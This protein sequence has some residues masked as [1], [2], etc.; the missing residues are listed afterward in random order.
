MTQE[1]AATSDPRTAW[2]G[3]HQSLL[4]MAIAGW[5]LVRL[6]WLAH[7]AL[8]QTTAGAEGGSGA[9]VH[10][11]EGAMIAAVGLAL[12]VALFVGWRIRT[13]AA[14]LAALFALLALRDP[15]RSLTDIIAASALI[16]VVAAPAAPWASVD[17][18]GRL[19]PDGGWRRPSWH[20]P[21][22]RLVLTL[23]ASG[24]A[25]S[26]IEAVRPGDALRDGIGVQGGLPES[27]AGDLPAL[28]LGVTLLTSAIALQISATARLGWVAASAWLLGLGLATD[29]V[30]LPAALALHWLA[31]M[32]PHWL[33]GLPCDG[34]DLVLYDGHCGL[35]HRA[36]RW[37][38]AED[39]DGQTF[40]FAALGGSTWQARLS[41]S[42]RAELPDSV[43][44]LTSDGRLLTRWR[45]VQ[46]LLARLG[47]VWALLQL[48]TAWIPA[49]LGDAGY[50]L[51]AAIRHRL[52]QAPQDA[53]PLLPPTLR[54]RLLP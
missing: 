53:C 47:G 22:A 5:M 27:W 46:H 16:G 38:L 20:G 48:A 44:V 51:V 28:P 1:P 17:A 40:R 39:A 15:L 6:V 42:D 31:A 50:E 30:A 2:T 10:G 52:F 26:L 54:A 25:L 41:A 11:P 18:L 19:D 4:R 43:V 12:A 13:V 36:V 45:A 23:L 21:L 14:L 49:R 3:G 24:W 8:R 33:P 7:L 29:Y 35:C 37:L 34:E 32:E 9:Q